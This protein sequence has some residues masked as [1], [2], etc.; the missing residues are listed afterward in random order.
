[1]SHT[2]KAALFLA[3]SSEALHLANTTTADLRNEWLLIATNYASLASQELEVERT[4]FCQ[5]K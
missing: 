1:M 5:S 3:K 2:E 4:G